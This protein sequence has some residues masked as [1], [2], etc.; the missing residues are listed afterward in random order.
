MANEL[1]AFATIQIST[2]A[3]FQHLRQLTMSSAQDLGGAAVS[4]GVM[5]VSATP[6]AIPLGDVLN[7]G[8]AYFKNLSAGAVEIG[9]DDGS[10]APFLRLLSGQIAGPMPLGA[11]PYAAADAGETGSLEYFI[12]EKELEPS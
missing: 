6:A 10:F 8:W 5:S 12:A 3:G 7:P 4:S 11:A 1:Q 2:T 9:I